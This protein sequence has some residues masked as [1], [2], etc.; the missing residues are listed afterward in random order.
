M[1]WYCSIFLSLSG[2]SFTLHPPI[3]INYSWHIPKW[4]GCQRESLSGL[5]EHWWTCLSQPNCARAT[6]TLPTNKDP[7]LASSRDAAGSPALL[8]NSYLDFLA[9]PWPWIFV[10]DLADVHQP[11][12]RACCHHLNS[13]GLGSAGLHPVSVGTAP[14]HHGCPWP[15]ALWP[16]LPVP[17]QWAQTSSSPELGTTETGPHGGPLPPAVL[18]T[19]NSAPRPH[20]PQPFHADWAMV[21]GVYQ[22]DVANTPCFTQGITSISPPFTPDSQERPYTGLPPV[23]RQQLPVTEPQILTMEEGLEELGMGDVLA[24]LR[25]GGSLWSQLR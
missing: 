21:G 4:A 19:H 6:P 2:C 14:L 13:A 25:E 16:T 15:P 22:S 5:W 24:T 20:S 23:W 8:M 12:S 3:I 1:Q 9:C 10:L 11:V 7:I 18:Q 17:W